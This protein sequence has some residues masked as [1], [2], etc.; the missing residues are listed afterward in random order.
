MASAPPTNPAWTLTSAW[1]AA[2]HGVHSR[3]EPNT[4]FRRAS[5]DIFIAADTAT[6]HTLPEPWRFLARL[7]ALVPLP[8]AHLT[9]FHGVLAPHAALRTTRCCRKGR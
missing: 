4:A 6:A 9:R 1:P 7:A 2:S 5:S 3:H 8:R